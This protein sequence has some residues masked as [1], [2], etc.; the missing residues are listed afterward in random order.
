MKTIIAT[1]PQYIQQLSKICLKNNLYLRDGLMKEWLIYHQ[2][3][4]E[5]VGIVYHQNIPIA[6]STILKRTWLG[7]SAGIYVK[8]QFR[9]QR[10]GN[11]LFKRII[12]ESKHTT[13]YVS[14]SLFYK[15]LQKDIVKVNL[16]RR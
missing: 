1:D 15:K 3:S 16:T 5:V 9:K 10:I 14:T 6:F 7:L 2:K 8:K 13:L 11:R 12:K 4:I